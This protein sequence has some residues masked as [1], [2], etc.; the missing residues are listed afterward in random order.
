MPDKRNE[1]SGAQ[2][3]DVVWPSCIAPEYRHDQALS[4][5]ER[6]ASARSESRAMI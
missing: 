5:Y 4:A 2:W 3:R 6:P 1:G